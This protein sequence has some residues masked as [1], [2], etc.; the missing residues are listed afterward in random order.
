M[1][2]CDTHIHL[3]AV[4]GAD[5][6]LSQASKA[7]I[8]ALIQPGVRIAGW[9][10]MLRLAE[11]HAHVYAAPGVHPMCA[12]QWDDEAALR[13]R[14]SVRQPKVVAIGEIGLDAAVAPAMEVQEKVLRAQLQIALDAG[15]PVLLHCR[16]Q[17]GALLNILRELDIGPRVGGIWHG[18]S[19]S[20]AFARQVVALG[21]ALGIGPIL[22]RDHVR[23]LPEVVAGLPAG[24]LVLETDY[25][26]M[27]ADPA[28]LLKVAEKVALL[29]GI[30]LEQTAQMTT[31]NARRL[32][33]KL[34]DS[35]R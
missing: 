29:R 34:Q 18:F 19:A 32:F 14:E 12:D 3:S 28:D 17:N 23:K 10:E 20:L 25:P 33:P 7:G 31:S 8:N 9:D 13:L 4:G 6:C 5:A 27:A 24:A 1:H 30:N 22:L 16:H 11:R 2:L 21:F 35:N 15:L 26:E